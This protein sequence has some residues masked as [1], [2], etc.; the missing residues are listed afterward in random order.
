MILFRYAA[1][2]EGIERSDG[3]IVY[4]RFMTDRKA[5]ITLIILFIFTIIFGYFASK[6]RVDYEFE[7]FF[8]ASSNEVSFFEDFRERFETD[9]DFLMLGIVEE[10]G[11]IDTAFLKEIKVLISD[12]KKLNYVNDVLGATSLRRI[13]REP[14]TGNLMPKKLLRIN[15]EKSLLKDA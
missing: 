10:N 12:L 6:A 13:R 1:E 9:N 11:V 7:K 4:F 8:P 14:L 5:G 3:R 2:D 15:N